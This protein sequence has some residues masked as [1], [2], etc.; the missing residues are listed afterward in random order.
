MNEETRQRI[1]NEYLKGKTV[2]EVA[3]DIGIHHTT[4]LYWLK[5]SNILRRP[6][7]GSR[8]HVC[9]VRVPLS[10]ITSREG[11]PDFDYFLGI[12]ATDGN[13]CRSKISLQF[14]LENSEILDHWKEFL[15]DR[16]DIKSFTRKDSGR[17]YKEIKFKNAEIADYYS[18]FGITE[19]KT[20]T[21]KLK[22]INWN[23]LRGIFDGDGCLHRDTRGT[24]SWRFS[25]CSASIDFIHQLN[26]FFVSNNLHPISSKTNN[27]YNISIGRMDEIYFIYTNIYKDSS[28]FLKRK[29]D[30]FWSL[31]EKSRRTHSVN[32]VKGRENHQT[33]PSPHGKVQRLE[34]EYLS[35]GSCTPYMVNV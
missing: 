33:E 19:R 5:K 6:V 17:T 20:F 24:E 7:K 34:T 18:T 21:L 12:L 32:S 9:K 25:I 31:L 28:Y 35:R 15:E 27:Y 1:C 16:V 22:Y 13:I 14:S 8:F 29:Y 2:R 23:V 26:D 30:K 10:V 11:T 4:V 3:M